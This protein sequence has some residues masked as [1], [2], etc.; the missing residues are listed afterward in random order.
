MGTPG[1]E[2][3]VLT[4]DE[5]N[6]GYTAR[7]HKRL[8][9][10]NAPFS[11]WYCTGVEDYADEY[12]DTGLFTCELCGC[13]R[14]RFVHVMRNDEYFEDISVGCICAGV[15]EGSILAA[16]ERER[17][18]K[19]RAARRRNFPCRRWEET[20]GG[21]CFLRYRGIPVRIVRSRHSAGCYGAECAGRTVWM[22]KGRRIRDFPSAAYAAFDLADPAERIWNA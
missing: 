14:V 22:Y 13:R 10:W 4:E 20:A 3:V 19:N 21:G 1:T 18:M 7:C 15:M 2:E 5:M 17:R 12:A 11:G 8:K 9:E 6:R 16:K